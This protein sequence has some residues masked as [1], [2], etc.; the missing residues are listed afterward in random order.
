MKAIIT[1]LMMTIG[2][3]AYAGSVEAPGK[4]F[5]KMPAGEIVSRNLSIVVPERGQ[6][7]VILK[8]G[9]KEF[10]ADRF[11]TR[12]ANQAKIFYVILSEFPGATPGD[13]AVYRGVYTRGSNLAIYYGNVFVGKSTQYSDDGLHELLSIGENSDFKYAAGFYFS[14]KVPAEE[15]AAGL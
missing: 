1:A 10:K 8:A 9:D 3:A 11:F 6:G 2:T 14:A 15:S 12:E 13:I 4:V 7:D 5:Y